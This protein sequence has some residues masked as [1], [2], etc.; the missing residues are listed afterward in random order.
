MSWKCHEM[1][2]PISIIVGAATV[3]ILSSISL[4][5]GRAHNTLA[6]ETLK[7]VA[8]NAYTAPT[9][10]GVVATTTTYFFL[11]PLSGW[12]CKNED[13]SPSN[14]FYRRV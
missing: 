9:L 5:E 8:G 2:G 13:E 1:A 14:S 6:T 4:A 7:L 3:V 12:F 11:K 10:M